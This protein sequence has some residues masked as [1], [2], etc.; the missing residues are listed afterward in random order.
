[1]L[2]ATVKLLFTLLFA[3][4]ACCYAGHALTLY[5]DAPKYAQDFTHFDFVNPNAPQGGT[6]KL[7]DYGT[8]DS[9]NP[10]IAKGNVE[11]HIGLIYE[12]LTYQ[13]PDEPFTVYG[14]L[15]QDIKRADD[16]SAVTFTLNP[17]AKW[18]DGVQVSAQDVKF[19]FDILMEHGN[20]YYQHYYADVANVEIID[21]LTV[22]FN[23]KHK[24]N[25]ELPLIIGQLQILPKHFWENRDFS[26]T[27]LEHP[28]GSGPYKIGKIDAG[29]SIRYDKVKN[30][31]GQNLPVNKGM[32]N[33]KHIYVDYYRDM[34]VALEAFKG[35]NFD[36][37]VEYSAKDW[38]QGYKSKAL[39]DGRI[40]QIEIPNH[41]PTGM[42]AYIFNLRSPIFQD[43][44]V[45][46]ALNLLFDFEWANRQ[47]FF[48]SYKRTLSFF[49]G[50]ELAAT[51][52]PSADEL[53]ILNPLKD[54]LPQQVFTEVFA[55]PTTDGSGMI[56]ENKRKAYKLLVEAGFKIVDDKMIAPNG[57]PFKFEFM[58]HQV[59][60]ERV[61]LPFKRNLA[62]LGI[63]ME[64]RRVDVSQFINRMRSR[65]FDVTSVIW[66]QSN[67]PGNEQREFWHSASSDNPGSRN[68]LGLKD[69]AI[70]ALVDHVI[71]A[72]SRT[73]LI[74]ATRALDRALQWGY[75][76]I[77]NYHSP[78][79]RI[80]YWNKFGRPKQTAKYDYVLMSWWQQSSKAQKSDRSNIVVNNADVT[81]ESTALDEL[82][83]K[84]EQ[85]KETSNL[86][87]EANL[88]NEDLV[89]ELTE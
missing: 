67:S 42:Q 74:T 65:D 68:F 7:A 13:S 3:F 71:A 24:A 10:F 45:R 8:F 9:L 53:K 22:K 78:V 35:G 88:L 69:E 63:E 87:D 52:L 48:N 17:K 21:N 20:P 11:G 33:F 18:H 4:N 39:D 75:Y 32:Y 64:I 26:K 85:E 70:D 86:V 15:A 40:L 36:L 6:L 61:L 5:D 54:K 14:L 29:R 27:S 25:R 89:K 82:L 66:G 77:P 46:K 56:R 50:S 76:L 16:N 19:S 44:R 81:T 41:N 83:L 84:L 80:A 43:I 55:L 73:Q 34:A 2:N 12:T 49:A 58:N 1:M 79:W 37:R 60:L 47:L 38:A 62:E 51:G 57:L 23:F 31:W 59:S 72:H 30:W 28:L